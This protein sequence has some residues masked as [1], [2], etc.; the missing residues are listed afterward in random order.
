M[1]DP[2]AT[3]G[4]PEVFQADVAR[5][6]LELFDG[7]AGP[8]G[9]L[10][11]PGAVRLA[12]EVL[13]RLGLDSDVEASRLHD[14]GTAFWRFDF[15]EDG[16][17]GREDAQRLFARLARRWPK[18]PAR[19]AAA[20]PT[21]CDLMSKAGIG[22]NSLRAVFGLIKELEGGPRGLYS[23]R[24]L[25]SR[26]DWRSVRFYSKKFGDLAEPVEDLAEERGLVEDIVQ[27]LAVLKRLQCPELV[28]LHSWFQ[29][30]DGI[31]LV[32]DLV[33]TCTSCWRL[34]AARR[35]RS[36][37]RPP[38]SARSLAGLGT[39]TSTGSC[40]QTCARAGWWPGPGAARP[41]PADA[42]QWRA[43]GALRRPAAGH[44]RVHAS[45]GLAGRPVGAPGRCVLPGGG[46][47]P[48]GVSAAESG[49]EIGAPVSP[50]GG[51]P[52]AGSGA[53]VAAE[54]ER[55]T[56]RGE[57]DLRVLGETPLLQDL[58]G[59][60]RRICPRGPASRRPRGMRGGRWRRSTRGWSRRC[61]PN[62]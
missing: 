57:P 17:V 37:G 12:G 31:Y 29:D 16:R 53:A 60:M 42:G 18:G 34:P 27:E 10:D 40:T 24:V 50:F 59:S 13:A 2:T 33:P 4:R 43:P 9:L 47:L 14:V 56:L 44:A 48:H 3:L 5:A 26:D 8:D 1:T 6:S 46:A 45:G 58:V 30:P 39:C 20:A 32:S 41:A 11:A 7:C 15:S 51:E 49:A 61:C 36:R 28:R 25:R 62:Q 52:G 55:A 22:Q 19:E 54:A 38:C 23:A 21:R 35:S